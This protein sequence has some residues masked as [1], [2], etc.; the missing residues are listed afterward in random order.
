M[1]I[2]IYVHNYTLVML[3]IIDIKYEFI[4]EHYKIIMIFKFIN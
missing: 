2:F 3:A 4:V 1:V